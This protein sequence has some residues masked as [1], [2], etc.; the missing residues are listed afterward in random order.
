MC[1]PDVFAPAQLL[2]DYHHLNHKLEKGDI[3][4]VLGSHDLRVADHAAAL[5]HEGWAPRVLFSGGMAHRGDL[6]ETGWDKTEAEMLCQ[7]AMALGL[8]SDRIILETQASN[9]GEN[10]CFSEAILREKGIPFDRVIALQ[11][12]YMERRSYATIRLYWPEKTVIISS[13]PISFQNYPNKD[14][15]MEQLINIMVGDLQRIIEYPARGYQIP[16]PV[17]P[18]VMEAYTRLKELGFTRHLI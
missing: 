11:K 18:A 4:F 15:S 16:Q 14:I 17:P 8:P 13:P 7:R 12:P 5:F 10:V 2:W 1:G 3:L 9:T 6:L